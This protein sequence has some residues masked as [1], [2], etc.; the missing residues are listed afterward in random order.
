MIG[1]KMHETDSLQRFI[2]EHAS[3][4]GEI[5]RLDQTYQ[6]IIQQRPYPLAVKRLLGEA[7]ISCL[8]LSG[9]IKYE[10]EISLQFHGDERLPLLLVQC[11]HQLQ[12]RAFAKY[13]ETSEN[14]DY[15]AAFLAGKMVLNISPFNQTQ[16]YQS[17]VPIQSNSMSENLIN[18]FAQSEQI[19]TQIWLA[20]DD[21]S[22]AGMLLQLLPDKDSRQREEF[23]QYAVVLGQTITD[24]EL[25][26]LDNKTILHRLYHETELR[27]F[28]ARPINF[29]CRCSPEKMK[30]LLLLLGE[31]DTQALMKERGDVEVRC[32]FCNQAYNFDAIDVTLL[33]RSS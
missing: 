3:I 28:D 22:A 26:S 2:F 4:R 15:N 33:F 18:Y 19:S 11:D 27:L 7:L 6:T 10:G 17:V 13:Q 32:D 8:L 14:I 30:K 21:N 20:V 29:H 12:I 9:S 24:Q 25:L 5:V 16:T 31:K 23:W 1:F